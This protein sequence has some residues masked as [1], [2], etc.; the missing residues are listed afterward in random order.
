[1]ISVVATGS[2]RLNSQADEV[3]FAGVGK[4]GVYFH[5]GIDF[6]T[7]IPQLL[8]GGQDGQAGEQ[9]G[10]VVVGRPGGGFEFEHVAVAC[11]VGQEEADVFEVDACA[12]DAA[13]VAFGHLVQM[14]GGYFAAVGGGA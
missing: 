13:V 1:M 3:G 10:F 14:F 5:A 7:F 6:F 2:S 4:F 8:Q 11:V 12:V 9:A